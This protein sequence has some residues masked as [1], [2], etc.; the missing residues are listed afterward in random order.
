[1]IQDIE[2]IEAYET[3]TK[4]NIT[5]WRKIYE[6]IDEYYIKYSNISPDDFIRE[7]LLVILN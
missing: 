7:C 4:V 1:M 3:I 5:Q 6:V 2:N